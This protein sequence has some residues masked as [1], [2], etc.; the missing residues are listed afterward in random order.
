M[1]QQESI[2]NL[3][4]PEKTEPLRQQVYKSKY[5]YN[6]PPTG[7]TFG[8]HTSSF[9]NA[10]NFSGDY[11]LPRGAHPIRKLYATFG[12]PDGFLLIKD[13]TSEIQRAF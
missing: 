7:T 3:I 4:P 2:Y 6:I 10:A 8:L 11:S 12:K 9:P 1:Y 13:P 5:P